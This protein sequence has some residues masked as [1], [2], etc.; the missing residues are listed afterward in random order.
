MGGKTDRLH[1]A[2][3]PVRGRVVRVVP[4]DFTYRGSYMTGKPVHAGW[5][6][7]LDADGVQVVLRER[8]VMPF[9]AEELLVLGIEPAR[10]RIIVTKAAIAWRAAYGGLATAVIEVD[11]PGACAPNL[12]SLVY[13]RVRRPVDPL[14]RDVSW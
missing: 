5:A 10:C 8:K 3:V 14:D 4:A 12:T 7:V 2:P 9:D 13:R 6:A 1:G 11:T